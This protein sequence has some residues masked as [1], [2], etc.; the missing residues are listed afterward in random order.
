MKPK[1]LLTAILVFTLGFSLSLAAPALA[2]QSLNTGQSSTDGSNPGER[3]AAD[4][5][6][7][8]VFYQSTWPHPLYSDLSDDGARLVA[9]IPYSGSDKTTRNIVATEMDG[10]SW[11]T[12]VVIAQNGAYSDETLQILPQVTHPVISGDGNTIAYVGYTGVTYGVYVVDR[13]GDAWS[14]PSLINTGLE[15]T[16]YWI[17]ISQDGSTLALCNYPFFGTQ[18][19][20][21]VTRNNGTWSAPVTIGDGRYPSLSADGKRLAYVF[22]VDVAF[23]EKINGSWTAPVNLTSY[24]YLKYMVDYPQ[25]S[26]DGAS[27]YYWIV[28]SVPSGTVSIETDQNLYVMRRTGAA[29]GQPQRINKE[30]VLPA[31]VTKG[32]AAADYYANRF[33]FSVPVTETQGSDLFVLASNLF[34]TEWVNGA[35][36]EAPLVEYNGHGN[37]NKW[38]QLTPDGKTLTF[39]AGTRYIPGELPIYDALWKMTTTDAPYVPVSVSA[40]ISPSGGSLYSAID[41]TSYIFPPGTFPFPVLF[42]HTFIP[43]PAPPPIG[44]TDIGH[45]FSITAVLSTTGQPVQPTIPFTVTIDYSSTGTGTAITNT[46]GLFTLDTS[47]WTGIGGLN[48]A[49]LQKMFGPIGHLSKFTVLG[50]THPLFLPVVLQR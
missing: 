25:M 20:Y 15:N 43:L 5:T 39:D 28:T 16:H 13:Q 27:I 14:T 45:S 47:N 35:W 1:I 8:A 44:M 38:P 41:Q 6:D 40:L 18:Q 11:K 10:G 2:T 19:V 49:A 12:P 37:Y 22:S 21:V 33:I 31:E 17:S 30:R 7:P 32:P 42:T 48:N 46:L 9:L 50:E 29:W 26:G 23:S 4:W 34:T 24:D 36:Q 3:P